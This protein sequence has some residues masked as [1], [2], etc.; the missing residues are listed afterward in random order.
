MMSEIVKKVQYGEY[1]DPFEWLGVHPLADGYVVRDFM[2]S[3]SSVELVGV[4]NMKPIE[5]TDTFVAEL[6]AEQYAKL[7]THYSLSWQEKNN[8]GR[9]STVSPYSFEP[10]LSSFDLDLFSAGRH[11]HIYKILGASLKTIDGIEGC[12]FAVWVPNVKRVSVIGDFNG[13]NGL[14]H[15]MRNRGASGVWELFI[16]GLCAGD[17]YKYE[18][19]TSQDEILYKS[20]PYARAMGM[21]P[22]TTS[23]VPALT[24][25]EWQDQEWLEQRAGRKWLHEPMSVYEVHVGSWRR[26]DDGSFLSYVELAEQLVP[27]VRDLGYTHIELLPVTEHPLDESWGYQVCGYYAPTSRHGNAEQL[28]YFIDACHANNIGVLLDWVPAHFP[29]DE[30]A[31]ARFNG[32]PCYEYGDP[33]KG[34]HH[35]WGT[36]IFNYGRNEV[37]NFLISNAVY[38]IEEF[39]IDGLRVDAVASMLYLDY[40]RKHG[41]WTPNMFGGREHLEAMDFLR[42]LNEIV[43]SDYPGVLTLA[44]ESTDWPMVSRPI[45]MGGLGF[46]MKWNMGWMHDTLNYMQSDP[47]Y[48][49]FQQDQLTFSQLYAYSENFVLPLSHD[50]VVHMKRSM[51]DKMP[52]DVWQ[53]F[54]NLRTLYAYQYA[55]PGKKLLFMGSEFGQWNEWDESKAIDWMVAGID[56]HVG[57]TNLL[58]DLN[59]LYRDEKALHAFDFNAEGFQWISC[60]DEANSVLAFLRRSLHENVVCVFNFTPV[61]RENYVIGVPEPGSYIE[62]LNTDAVYYGGAGLGNQGQV[63]ALEYHQHGFDFSVRLTLPPLAALILRKA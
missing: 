9:Y 50:E 32:G 41:Q 33:N 2:P 23:L 62:L 10:I 56:K 11:L 5:G 12:L 15:P 18:I 57:L 60:D 1:H 36:L 13:W 28:R 20:D 58:R 55:H 37:R 39:H 19:R 47:V 52:G 63:E 61:P 42:N 31:L 6:T 38:W 16:P 4:G 30:F 44:E 54:A 24:V 45:D 51:L 59:H 27:Y 34:E 46:S 21:R 49:R 26:H 17:K 29:R 40:S 48:R 14:R 7:P 25:H 8:G 3:A 53:K 43:H 35:D 22:D